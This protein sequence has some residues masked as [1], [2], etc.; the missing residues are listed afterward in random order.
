MPPT[1]LKI[2]VVHGV[3]EARLPV[4]RFD[5]DSALKS[6]PVVIEGSN[7]IESWFESA[8]TLQCQIFVS[9]ALLS[10]HSGMLLRSAK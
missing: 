3:G 9:L 6:I 7:K 5:S 10:P 4:Y 2:C 8:A 1:I